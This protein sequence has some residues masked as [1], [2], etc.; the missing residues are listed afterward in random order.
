[1][2]WI[3]LDWVSAAA[4]H[5]QHA[6][7]FSVWYHHCWSGRGIC[8]QENYR[9]TRFILYKAGNTKWTKYWY[10][11][12]ICQIPPLLDQFEEMIQY[13]PLCSCWPVWV[14]CWSAPCGQDTHP[15]LQQRETRWWFA[16]QAKWAGR[17]WTLHQSISN[18]TEAV[19]QVIERLEVKTKAKVFC[20]L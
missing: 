20:C 18:K 15:A 5:T 6:H 13:S 4:L 12:L 16:P 2:F 19:I 14:A 17:H 7:I 9:I 11:R 3:V 10:V 8:W 1:M